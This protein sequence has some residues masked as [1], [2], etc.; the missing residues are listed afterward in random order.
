MSLITKVILSKLVPTFE[1]GKIYSFIGCVDAVIPLVANPMYSSL[2]K[3]TL[4]SFAGA[5]FFLSAAMTISP[6]CVFM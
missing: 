5:F 6:F 2:Y 1:I 4:D 3:V